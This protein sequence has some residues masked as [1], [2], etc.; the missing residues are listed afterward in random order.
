MS[1]NFAFSFVKES[2]SIKYAGHTSNN[3]S[4]GLFSIE[5]EK[6]GA[7]GSR[8]VIL[9]KPGAYF[10]V[11]LLKVKKLKFFKKISFYPKTREI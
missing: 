2:P 4:A 9:S 6:N 10:P 8:P 3:T 1:T 11:N 5:S 7:A